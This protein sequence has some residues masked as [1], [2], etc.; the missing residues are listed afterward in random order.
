MS[1]DCSRCRQHLRVL[2]LSA[3]AP[4]KEE[5]HQAYLEAAKMSDPEQ[6]ADYPS[7][8]AQAEEQSK[9]IEVAYQEL[10][11]H[12]DSAGAESAVEATPADSALRAASVDSVY[13]AAPVAQAPSISLD[14]APGCLVAPNFNQAAKEVFERHMGKQDSPVAIVDLSQS[15]NG[16]FAQFFLLTNRGIMV[17]DVRN[18]VSVIWYADLGAVDLIDQSRPAK[19]VWQKFVGKIG[20]SPEGYVLQICRSNG[21]LFFSLSGE[22]SDAVKSSL[23]S[24][25]LQKKLEA[26]G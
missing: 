4:S 17:R 16:S 21:A 9:L 18:I 8:R 11:E 25:L 24:F 13:Q 22:T 12:C 19:S 6:V 20:G 23:H 3:E 26:Q 7:L 15:R 14:G 10:T 2:G 5:I 1:C